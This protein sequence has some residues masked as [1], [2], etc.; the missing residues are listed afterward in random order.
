M[1]VQVSAWI[2]DN[3]SC[4][5]WMKIDH[6]LQKTT[7]K[8]EK[9]YN[10][11]LSRFK[12]KKTSWRYLIDIGKQ[13]V[14]TTRGSNHRIVKKHMRTICLKKYKKYISYKIY[15]SGEIYKTII[16]EPTVFNP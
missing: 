11:C 2:Y 1:M 9:H 8:R 3:I 6:F 16:K 7:I 12:D 13:T 5:L 4:Q 10:E 14:S 15:Q